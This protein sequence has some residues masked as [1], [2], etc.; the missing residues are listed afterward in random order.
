MTNDDYI[1]MIMMMIRIIIMGNTE[2]YML[3]NGDY[4]E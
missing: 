1:I 2:L 4:K 3:F